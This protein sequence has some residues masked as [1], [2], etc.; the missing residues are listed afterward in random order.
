MTSN[1][2][3]IGTPH[4][5]YEAGPVGLRNDRV[6]AAYG[7]LRIGFVILPVVMGIDKFTNVL[8]D[9]PGYLAPWVVALLPF[10]AATAMQIVGVIEIAAGFIVAVRPR[11]GAPIVALW[12]VGIIVN[13]LTY[14][15]YYDVAMRDVGLLIGAITLALLADAHAPLRHG[16]RKP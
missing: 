4:T 6:T 7:L 12:L 9:W 11:I 3:E 15:G 10:S 16:R 1:P 2:G 13:L 14:P 8:T 5:T